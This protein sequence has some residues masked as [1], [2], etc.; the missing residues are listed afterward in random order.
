MSFVVLDDSHDAVFDCRSVSVFFVCLSLR[1][2]VAPATRIL[3]GAQRRR[4]LEITVAESFSADHRCALPTCVCPPR[5]SHRRHPTTVGDVSF[6]Q[7]FTFSFQSTEPALCWF[8]PT[9]AVC[10]FAAANIH[11]KP[12]PPKGMAPL[13]VEPTASFSL[14]VMLHT[15]VSFDIMLFSDER[16]LYWSSTRD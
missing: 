15:K 8:D 14:C 3:R 13:L 2:R 9:T 5:S 16:S 10:S 12:S 11:A 6:T 1:G 7:V 4:L